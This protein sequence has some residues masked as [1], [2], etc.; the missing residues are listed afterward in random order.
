MEFSTRLSVSLINDYFIK[1]LERK[2][3]YFRYNSAGKILN[4]IYEHHRISGFI[5]NNLFGVIYALV[6]LIVFSILLIGYNIQ[7]YF[8]LSIGGALYFFWISSFIKKRKEADDEVYKVSALNHSKTL[9]LINGAIELKLN[10][11]VLKRR[12]QWLNIQAKLLNKRKK[13]FFIS[14]F[15]NRVSRFILELTT[16]I[17]ILFTLFAVVEDQLTLGML[18]SIQYIMNHII[19]SFG[20]FVGFIQSNQDAKI[21]FGRV[22]EIKNFEAEESVNGLPPSNGPHDI[23]ISNVSFQYASTQ[24]ETL[25]DISLNIKRGSTVAIVGKR[26]SGKSTLLS[27]LTLVNR[28]DNGGIK[29]WDVYLSGI[30]NESW[31]KKIGVVSNDSFLFPDTVAHNICESSVDIDN[32]QMMKSAKMA[33]VHDEVLNFKR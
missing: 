10:G 11:S 33:C 30:N 19:N 23:S 8:I 9:E 22:S 13:S 14:E 12:W 29:I 28:P 21:S 20:S 4:N 5:T 6:N 17:T 31:R 25:N 2:A 16:N 24:N 26:G 32:S 18:L 1:L 3:K 27:L 15:Q 7:L